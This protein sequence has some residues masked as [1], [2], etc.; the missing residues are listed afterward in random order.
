MH[1]LVRAG[2][3]PDLKAGPEPV[4]PR[5][6]KKETGRGINFPL[7]SSYMQ[8]NYACRRKTLQKQNRGERVLPGARRRWWGSCTEV[9]G[10]GAAAPSLFG[11][12]FSLSLRPPLS[13]LPSV[14][15][16]FF[17][18]QFS[19]SIPFSFSRACS[20]FSSLLGS[21]SLYSSRGPL[22]S[23]S[24]CPVFLF[25]FIENKT[26]Q[27]RLSCVPSITQRLVGHWGEFGGGG[28][29]ERERERRGI[30]FKKF[31]LLF[32]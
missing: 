13:L 12:R 22:F 31:R 17:Y 29:E 23:S 6:E 27:V 16:F 5:R 11:V 24:F 20:L 4:W 2:P 28:G 18:F 14:F 8:H 19:S 26:E 1:L 15:F 21:L 7:P 30:F 9:P 10:G 25:L 32:C 3:G